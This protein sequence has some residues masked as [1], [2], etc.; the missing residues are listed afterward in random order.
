MRWTPSSTWVEELALH[1]P[2]VIGLDDLQWADPSSLLT[3]SALA[4]RLT[5]LPLALR[6]CFRPSPRVPQLQRAIDAL[7]TAGASQLTLRGLTREAV[8]ALVSEAVGAKPGPG[9]LR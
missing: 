6:C 2:L 5:G 4:R 1:A 9:L 8:S 7:H 3:I